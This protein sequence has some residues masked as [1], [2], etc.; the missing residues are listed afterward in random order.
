MLCAPRL[1]TT[2]AGVT[3]A[4]SLPSTR[5]A[6]PAGSL[7]MEAVAV[8]VM[9]FMETRKNAG[10]PACTST[11]RVSPTYP[12][13]LK[14]TVCGPG[15]TAAAVNG[16]RQSGWPLPSIFTSAPSGSV[17]TTS[18]ARDVTADG[19]GSLGAGMDSLD[20]ASANGVDEGSG[21][22]AAVVSGGN[23][24]GVFS[25]VSDFVCCSCDS[26]STLCLVC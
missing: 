2:C 19:V 14:V 21:V 5:M 22:A 20:E 7:P 23:E 4:I 3:W 11:T 15:G 26:L 18:S 25:A 13:L 6:A 12:L 9:T 8:G 10:L 16:V 17:L 24:V 1:S